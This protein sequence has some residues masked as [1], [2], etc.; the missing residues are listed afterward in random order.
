MQ[1]IKVQML[2]PDLHKRERGRIIVV[3]VAEQRKATLS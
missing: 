1:V 3:C 2:G